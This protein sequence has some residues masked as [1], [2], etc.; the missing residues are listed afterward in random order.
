METSSLLASYSGVLWH[1]VIPIFALLVLAW[2]IK[3]T[4]VIVYIP[5]NRVG[6]VEMLWSFQGSIDSGLIALDGRAG[7]KPDVL[8]GGFH[9]FVPTMYRVHKVPLVTIPQGRIGYVFARDG[10]SLPTGQILASNKQAADFDDV[11]AFLGHGGQKGPQRRLLREGTYA[12]NLAQF[13]VITEGQTY[14]LELGE[15]EESQLQEMK[16]VIEERDGFSP[17]VIH[18]KLDKI[19]VVTIHDGPALPPGEIIAPEAGTRVGEAHFHNNFQDPEVFLEAGGFRGRQLQVLVDGTYALNRLFATVELVDKTTIEVGHVGVVTFYAGPTG[20]DLSGEAFRHGQLVAK[21]HRGVWQDVLPPGKYAFNPF[22]GK[23]VTVPTTNFVLKWNQSATGDH[24]L[25][26]NLAEIKLITQDAFSPLL[27][28]SVVLH[29]DHTKAPLVIQ[30]FGDIKRLVEQTLDPLVSAYFKNVGQV[31]NYLDLVQDRA[32]IQDRA[33]AEM[34]LK[35]AAYNLELHEV[36]IGTPRAQE[37]DTSIDQVLTQ[38]RQRQIADEQIKTFENQQ[39]AAEKERELNEAKSVAAMQTKLTESKIR[40]NVE[41][42][43]GAANL[44]RARQKADQTIAEA[45]AARKRLVLEGNGEAERIA[46]IGRAN[47]EATK[48][49]VDAYGGPQYRLSEILGKQFFEAIAAGKIA[50]V[51]QIQMGA[52]SNN[53]LVEGMLALALQG[54]IDQ[55]ILP[56]EAQPQGPGYTAPPRQA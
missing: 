38:L 11:R 9:F 15:A 5:N 16:S 43:E 26:E 20:A 18:N 52:T 33:T 36:L 39:K 6:V 28:L 2:I 25:D 51:P 29:I 44:A 8:R 17:V 55:G 10:Q 47:A 45:E 32:S 7:F 35:F 53:G 23:I 46:N 54:K 19:G 49:Q 37:G 22:A 30:R 27:P 31:R 50:I 56:P 42:N 4:H 41:E 3:I 34:A 1:V 12:I 14:A 21:G 40:I 48:A 13:V 24:R